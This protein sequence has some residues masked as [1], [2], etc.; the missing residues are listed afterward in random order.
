[1]ELSALRNR[2]A[3][4]ENTLKRH[5]NYYFFS[6]SHLHIHIGTTVTAVEGT[7][8]GLKIWRDEQKFGWQNL[9]HLVE[10]DLSDLPKI[11]PL[12]PGSAIPTVVVGWQ[13]EK[14]Y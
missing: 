10:I 13:L 3:D 12:P 8:E 1:M 9:T 5:F 11:C 14:C 6:N 2:K 4:Q 7:A